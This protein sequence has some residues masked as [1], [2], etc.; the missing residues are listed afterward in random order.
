MLF[1]FDLAQ[2]FFNEVVGIGS[3]SFS[4]LSA[5]ES[6]RNP[7]HLG[8]AKLPVHEDALTVDASAV[9]FSDCV[10]GISLPGK[11]HKRVASRLPCLVGDQSNVINCAKDLELLTDAFFS[12]AV[13]EAPDEDGLVW[14]GVSDVFVFEWLP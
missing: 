3:A 7:G 10:I 14:I 5:A 4:A 2:D 8:A 9:S 13:G 1:P 12:C 11:G 6:A